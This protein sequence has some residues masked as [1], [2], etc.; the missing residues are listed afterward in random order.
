MLSR[1]GQQ[2]DAEENNSSHAEIIQ[3]SFRKDCLRAFYSSHQLGI[4]LSFNRFSM[5]NYNDLKKKNVLHYLLFLLFYFG[6]FTKSLSLSLLR[7]VLFT[8][9]HKLNTPELRGKW[10]KTTPCFHSPLI[11]QRALQTS[12]CVCVRAHASVCACMCVKIR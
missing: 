10:A 1:G 5:C 7:S 11:L 6:R 3:S 9:H 12:Q 4:R 8:L 2:V